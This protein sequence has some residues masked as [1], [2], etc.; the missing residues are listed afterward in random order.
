MSTS[1]Q[2]TV[3]TT[4][5][6]LSAQ[7]QQAAPA[8]D[9]RLCSKNS[10]PHQ[11]Y[12]PGRNQTTTQPHMQQTAELSDIIIIHNLER[13][14]GASQTDH[15]CT[16]VPHLLPFLRREGCPPALEQLSHNSQSSHPQ[17]RSHVL[18]SSETWSCDVHQLAEGC[19]SRGQQDSGQCRG[20][21]AP[22]AQSHAPPRASAKKSQPVY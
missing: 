22:Q 12:R 20:D 8:A 13:L 1:H 18:H 6:Q 17:P 16:V 3:S 15:P 19:D 5:A 21:R 11:H 14:L 9:L 7:S 4:G 10:S 2:Q